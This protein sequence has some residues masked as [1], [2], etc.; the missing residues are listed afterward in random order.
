MNTTE[1]NKKIAEFMDEF[2]NQ[3]IDADN[4]F[5]SYVSATIKK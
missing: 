1:N 2:N 4:Y 3:E 5:M